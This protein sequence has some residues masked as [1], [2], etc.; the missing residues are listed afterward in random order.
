MATL[1]QSATGEVIPIA[2]RHVVGR[3]PTC[4]LRLKHP[5]VSGFHAE[6]LW[7]GDRWL[8]QDLG[9]RNGTFYGG[10][11][12]H[13]KERVPLVL[14]ALIDF[15]T[16]EERF[17]V[18]DVGPPMLMAVA[19]DGTVVV[20][21]SNMLAIPSAA[22]PEVV[23]FERRDGSWMLESPT[24]SKPVDE[25][26]KITAGAQEWTI[27]VPCQ[28]GQTQDIALALE[29]RTR[30][31]HFFVSRDGEFVSVRLEHA[32]G[33]ID[34]SSAAHVELL[35]LLAKARLADRNR[36][37]LPESEHG[38]MYR[39]DIQKSLT[40]SAS[41]LNVWVHRARTQFAKAGLLSPGSLIERR[42]GTLQLRIGIADLHV[43]TA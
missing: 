11:P 38:W 20:A 30:S 18:E 36:D 13:P 21:E 12:L 16:A 15:G 35:C 31:L 14:G 7:D 9:S 41:L 4:S 33:S 28:L 6:L 2:T 40:I 39:E 24:L 37:D 23:V 26:C 19:T 32:R 1:R 27:C 25:D 5:S 42:V 17:H 34:F 10:R 29:P 22:E 3:A 43:E 8:L